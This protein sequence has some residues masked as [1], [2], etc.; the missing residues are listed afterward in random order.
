VKER[1]NMISGGGEELASLSV[2]KMHARTLPHTLESLVTSNTFAVPT[3]T[4]I[5]T[6]S[7]VK[8]T[9]PFSY[10]CISTITISSLSLGQSI[11]YPA[12]RQCNDIIILIAHPLLHLKYSRMFGND[13]MPSLIVQTGA[14]SCRTFG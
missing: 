12:T 8:L 6:A 7:I 14:R 13:P 9:G 10:A 3:I 5:K 1:E 4:Y 11:M 2:D